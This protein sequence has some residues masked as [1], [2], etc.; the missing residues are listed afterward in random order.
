MPGKGK[1]RR[2]RGKKR[3]SVSTDLDALEDDILGLVYRVWVVYEAISSDPAL[4]RGAANGGGVGGDEEDLR[5]PGA[6]GK[7]SP[8][9]GIDKTPFGRAEA[10]FDRQMQCLERLEEEIR[11]IEVRFRRFGAG[12]ISHKSFLFRGA[13]H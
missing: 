3:G 4:P 5:G 1:P 8:T 6:Q 7:N 13:T 12:C 9:N 10:A 2:R 11:D